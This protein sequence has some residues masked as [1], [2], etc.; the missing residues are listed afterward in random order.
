MLPTV[1]LLGIGF[2]LCFPS[3]N[4]QAT[5]GVK[6]EEQGLASGILNSSLQVGGA[7][8]LAVVTAILGSGTT[9]V[10]HNELLPHMK[11]A[12]TVCVGVTV[13]ALIATAFQQRTNRRLALAAAVRS[14]AE[15]EYSA[16]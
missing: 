10:R 5:L 14:E 9:H 2:S 15:P 1:L 13:L 6:D 3:V 8:V 11:I 4:V 16:A 7:V 12:I